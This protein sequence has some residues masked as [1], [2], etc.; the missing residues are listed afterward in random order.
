[1]D[2]FSPEDLTQFLPPDGSGWKYFV[3]AAEFGQDLQAALDALSDRWSGDD[4]DEGDDGP[5]GLVYLPPGCTFH[6]PHPPLVIR[7]RNLLRKNGVRILGGGPSTRVICPPGAVLPTVGEVALFEFRGYPSGSG[8]EVSSTSDCSLENLTIDGGQPHGAPT[9]TAGI[10]GVR[11]HKANQITRLRHLTIRNCGGAGIVLED[12]S[13]T[14]LID[15]VTI[16]N[17]GTGI[18]LARLLPW[19]QHRRYLAA[20]FNGRVLAIANPEVISEPPLG[21]PD[22]MSGWLVARAAMA[23]LG[24]REVTLRDGS[25]EYLRSAPPSQ[26]FLEDIAR[27]EPTHCRIFYPG[28]RYDFPQ[29]DPAETIGYCV[30]SLDSHDD[31]TARQPAVVGSQSVTIRNCT[32]RNCLEHG[33]RVHAASNTRVL[34]CTIEHC[35]WS[36]VTL[37]YAA[38]FHMEGCALRRNGAREWSAVS[39]FLRGYADWS[40]A[41]DTPRAQLRIGDD[42]NYMPAPINVPILNPTRLTNLGGG[43]GCKMVHLS[44]CQFDGAGVVDHAISIIQSNTAVLNGCRFDQHTAAAVRAGASALGT[45]LLGN[46]HGAGETLLQSLAPARE[47]HDY[48]TP[49]G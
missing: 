8:S 4:G 3:N 31:L 5:G 39:P 14:N 23:S 30:L 19:D 33:I 9:S 32:I 28:R 36:G 13:N 41:P 6:V 16:E 25:T 1:M 37:Q 15:G 34:G 44:G 46:S 29:T 45:V 24:D 26:W 40:D 35:W 7:Q 47:V 21:G 42:F 48:D 10:I 17:C 2:F 22:V 20:E 43:A 49:L 12:N 11:L 38:T 18:R 27:P